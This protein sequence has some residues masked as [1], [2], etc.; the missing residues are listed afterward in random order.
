MGR[1]VFFWVVSV[2]FVC[3]VATP[4]LGVPARPGRPA[5]SQ[6]AGT[7]SP[8][9][10]KWESRIIFYGDEGTGEWSLRIRDKDVDGQRQFRLKELWQYDRDARR[11]VRLGTTVVTSTI[12]PADR[13]RRDPQNADDDTQILVTLPIDR[14]QVGLY[15]A[16]WMVDDVL[17][18]TFCRIGPGLEKNSP[19]ARQSPPEGK[20]YAVVPIDVKRAEA[21][22]ILDPRIQC[23]YGK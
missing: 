2:C 14:E 1:R 18:S 9:R 10:L 13:R 8:E 19:L 22:F 4:L 17:G 20:I 21:A 23:E 3:V 16:R 5:A 7:S 15:Y 12:V 11:W 6:P